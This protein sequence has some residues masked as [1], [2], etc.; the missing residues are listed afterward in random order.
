VEVLELA[1]EKVVMKLYDREEEG[2]SPVSIS[3]LWAPDSR[4]FAQRR[5]FKR[6][7]D[8]SVY[9][10]VEAG[11]KPCEMPSLDEFYPKLGKWNERK[12]LSGDDAP[13]RWTDPNHLII[14]RKIAYLGESQSGGAGP[15]IVGD[16]QI[17]L[18]IGND[19]KVT[20]EKVL[21]RK[22]RAEPFQ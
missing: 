7:A 14:A 13:Q 3:V 22:V 21:S 8:T 17:L 20:I 5:S 16:Y 1:T 11:F 19:R 6:F 15:M 10:R 12:F 2:E 4:R 9:E 18:R